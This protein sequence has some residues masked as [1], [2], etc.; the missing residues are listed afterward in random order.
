MIEATINPVVR[1]AVIEAHLQRSLAAWRMIDALRAW[2]ARLRA[3]HEKRA[4]PQD[5]PS[6][7]AGFAA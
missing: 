5:G 1:K 2:P 4:A 6:Y 7:P 3:K